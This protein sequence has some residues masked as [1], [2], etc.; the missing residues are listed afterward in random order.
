M[1]KNCEATL[2][3]IRCPF[4]RVIIL[5]MKQ[6]SRVYLR[7]FSRVSRIHKVIAS[8]TFPTVA[9]LAE[10]LDV[11]ERTIKRDLA[12][13][14]D[15]LNAPLKFDRKRKGFFYASEG[16]SP[17]LQRLSEGDLLAFFIAENSL[18]LTGQNSQ[19][20]QLKTSLSKI[21]QLLPDQVS[22]DIAM[23]GENVRFQNSPFAASDPD[24]LN[25][26]AGASIGQQT[27]E[28]DYFSPHAQESSHRKVDVYMLQ[29]F[30]GD[31]YAISF[32][33]QRQ[34][35]RDFHIGRMSNVCLTKKFF[36]KRS[37]WNADNYRNRGF[38]MT[39]GGRLTTVSIRFD[40]YQ[41]QWIR[42]RNYFHP[43]EVR[44]ELPDGGLRLSFK[45]GEKALEAV[46][47]FCLQ[48]AGNCVAE[49]PSKLTRL[50]RERL[51][52]GLELH[53]EVAI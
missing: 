17:P 16:W 24:I 8:N 32:D 48:Y 37:G 9:N 52:K 28:F 33:H 15:E 26:V 42:E 35:Y 44:E 7:A 25:L 10:A 14:R 19:A 39:R 43:E 36:D 50:V 53:R 29:N 30:A 40:T 5:D 20:L 2:K 3:D 27:I 4:A 46:A 45:V 41:A 22:F 49:K 38:S 12:V 31:W 47:R 1:H 23:L 34:D 51:Q 11:N 6:G 18:K 13:L 21:A